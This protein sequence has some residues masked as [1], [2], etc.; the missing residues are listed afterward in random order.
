LDPDPERKYFWLSLIGIA[1]L[2][3][4]GLVLMGILTP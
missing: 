3:L 2:G 4:F 1:A